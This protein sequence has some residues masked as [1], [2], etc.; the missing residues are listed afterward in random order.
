MIDMLMDSNA[1]I[2][3][4]AGRQLHV[5]DYLAVA[6][7]SRQPSVEFARIT[8]FSFG[9]KITVR[10]ATAVYVEEIEWEKN[11]DGTRRRE[12]RGNGQWGGFLIKA[13]HKKLVVK[14]YAW[15]SFDKFYWVSQ[16]SLPRDIFEVLDAM[17]INVV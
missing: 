15:R 7:G 12:D 13:K 1:P 14:N 9:K 17:E 16:H 4:K 3:D 8:K 11:P 5:G 10:T 6:L 2:L